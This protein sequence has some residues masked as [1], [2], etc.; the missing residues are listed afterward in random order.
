MSLVSF[1]LRLLF[2]QF[3]LFARYAF[4]YCERVRRRGLLPPARAAMRWIVLIP[5][6]IIHVKVLPAVW[7]AFIPT[8]ELQ[9][10]LGFFR[11]EPTLH[12]SSF[13]L[14]MYGNVTCHSFSS[15]LC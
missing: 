5:V 6:C 1:S 10:N 2:S 13:R 8:C 3:T 14:R 7:P 4:E 15:G 9:L 11:K 12:S